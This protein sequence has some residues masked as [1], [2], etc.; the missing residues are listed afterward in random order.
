MKIIRSIRG[1]QREIDKLHRRGKI[2]GFVPTMG[3]LHEGHL[4]LMRAAR[5]RCDVVVVSIFVNPTQFGPGEDYQRYPRDFPGDAKKCRSAGV[6]ILFAP[7]LKQIYPPDHRTLVSV[8]GLGDLL[9]GASR[10]GHFTGVAT[11]VLKLL[12]IVRPEKVFL[13]QKDYQQT[14]VIRRMVKDLHL[15]SEVVVCSTRREPDGLAMSSRNRYLSVPERRA[16]TVLWK[17]LR[18]GRAAI[19]KGDRDAS[20]VRSIL[21]HC[22]TQDSLAKLDYVAVMAPKTLEEVHE[23]RGPVVLALAVW[24]GKTRLIDNIIVRPSSSKRSAS[25]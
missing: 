4:S 25:F 12:V 15:D 2:V 24:I 10:P 19:E 5:R 13:G 23:I 20:R 17:A 18:E 16:A 8:K 9:E 21:T 11:V 7:S 22:I 3:A 1:I 6:D 14:V